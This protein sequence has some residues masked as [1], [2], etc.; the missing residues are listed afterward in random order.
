MRLNIRKAEDAS[1][2]RHIDPIPLALVE[3]R[4]G[5]RSAA[6]GMN[7]GVGAGPA[8]QRIVAGLSVEPIVAALTFQG[9]GIGI[10]GKRIREV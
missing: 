8:C 4:D 6:I 5:V 10:A 1:H 3:V 9:I 2:P 7:E